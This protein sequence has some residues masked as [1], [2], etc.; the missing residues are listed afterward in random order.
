MPLKANLRL[1]NRFLRV[2][3]S[4]GSQKRTLCLTRCVLLIS[5]ISDRLRKELRKFQK[6]QEKLL[7]EFRDT[8]GKFAL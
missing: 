7:R 6:F 4:V 8:V 3:I 1:A 5:K 2:D